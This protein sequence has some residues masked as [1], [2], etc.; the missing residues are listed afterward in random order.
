[1][2]IGSIILYNDKLGAQTL[3]LTKYHAVFSTCD[4]WSHVSESA[5]TKS[6]FFLFSEKGTWRRSYGEG[7]WEAKFAGKRLFWSNLHS[8]KH[9]GKGCA[10]CLF[11]CEV[12]MLVWHTNVG[13]VSDYSIIKNAVECAKWGYQ[14]HANNHSDI[15]LWTINLVASSYADNR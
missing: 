2:T 4:W 11:L 1:M 7:V 8:E 3:R 15:V 5:L 12:S 14:T 13:C 10:L 6:W 9:Q